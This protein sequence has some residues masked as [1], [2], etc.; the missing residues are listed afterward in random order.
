MKLPLYF[1]V[2][3][4]LH[5]RKANPFISG[6]WMNM[7]SVLAVP[8]S[9]QGTPS[10]QGEPTAHTSPRC[11]TVPALLSGL[12]P[13][14]SFNSGIKVTRMALH[15]S[16]HLCF[17][18]MLYYVKDIPA[19]LRYFHSL[20]ESQG[21]LLIIL[22]SGESSTSPA[23]SGKGCEDLWGSCVQHR[24]ERWT[25]IP[26]NLHTGSAWGIKTKDLWA[27][28]PQYHGH[29]TPFSA[30][31]QWWMAA[32]AP[33]QERLHPAALTHR[34]SLCCLLSRLGTA[35]LSPRHLWH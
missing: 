33:Q 3:W 8:E 14:G 2:H 25:D 28:P 11:L 30:L 31:P 15:M 26:W 21:K 7:S 1:Q 13:L 24:L 9:R 5:W 32:E 6:W 20:L 22:V 23:Q 35:F 10:L 29:K 19:T 34:S 12:S 18:Q 17:F 16:K 4:S 27:K